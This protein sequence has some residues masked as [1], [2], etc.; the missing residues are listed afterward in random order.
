MTAD[1]SFRT[2][3]IYQ[4]PLSCKC[5]QVWLKTW[6]NSIYDR[7]ENPDSIQ[8]D[9]PSRLKGT[10]MLS[11]EDV[12]FCR[13]PTTQLLSTVLPSVIVATFLVSLIGILFIL[14]F[15][16]PIYKRFRF[17]PFDRDECENEN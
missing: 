9:I 8:C 7:L 14:K 12:D 10:A 1:F 15:R 2:F 5:D 11:L 6:L 17:H 16:I 4:N 3:S 13:D